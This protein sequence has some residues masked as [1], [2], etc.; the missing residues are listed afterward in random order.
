MHSFFPT[1]YP[2][3]LSYSVLARYHLYSG[4]KSYKQTTF[5]LFDTY[6]AAAF[7]DLTGS[8]KRIVQRLPM[9]SELT[10]EIIVKNHTLF[11]FYAHFVPQERAEMVREHMINSGTGG[12]HSTLG[13][14]ASNIKMPI[15][16]RYCPECTSEDIQKHGETYWRRIHQLPGIMACHKH[17]QTL[18]NSTVQLSFLSKRE[19]VVANGQNCSGSLSANLMETD[20]LHMRDLA[21]LANSILQGDYKAKQKD[22]FRKRYI[23]FLQEAGY[24]TEGG[25]VYKE[26]LNNG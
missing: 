24:V 11:P 4:N 13:L 3:E 2:D 12:I 23:E 20:L 1:P 16:L 8:I 22:F 18:M 21:K 5:E 15:H 17:N 14:V 25:R 19:Y 10:A 7:I 9:E 6:N 26:K